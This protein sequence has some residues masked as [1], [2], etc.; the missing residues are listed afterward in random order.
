MRTSLLYAT[1][2]VMGRILFFICFGE[3]LDII[4]TSTVQWD[5]FVFHIGF[6]EYLNILHSQHCM[7]GGFI[8]YLLGFSF[9]SS[10]LP[11]PLGEVCCRQ[12]GTSPD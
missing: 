10:H 8:A 1:D 6:G 5:D 4:H 11:V 3:Y 2:T 12:I 7:M 9:S